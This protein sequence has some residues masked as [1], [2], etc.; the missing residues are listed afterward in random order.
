MAA[1]KDNKDSSR[2]IYYKS[3]SVKDLNVD[4]ESRTISGYAAVWGNK[5]DARDILIKG[6]CAKSIA[7]RGPQ[8]TTNRKI[9]L[10]WMHDCSEPLG[11]ILV[12]KEDETGLYFEAE[13][14]KIPEGD[15][16]LA[17]LKSGTLNQ[18]SIGYMYIWDKL[19]YDAE[20]DAFIVKE[21]S[22]FEISVVSI[23]MNEMTMFLGLKTS[24]LESERNKLLRDTDAV[25][26]GL[27]YDTQI[28]VK[29]LI[30]KHIALTEAEPGKPLQKQSEPPFSISKA[31]SNTQFFSNE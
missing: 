15:R 17:Q 25:L 31:I 7:D 20:Q 27:P 1:K 13:I 14:D 28:Q 18:F 22:L 21:I 29:Q 30:S 23:G 12:L 19:E 10:L 4:E 11:K 2:P 24:Q 9:I 3:F 26:K 5:D 16:C 6:C 8:S